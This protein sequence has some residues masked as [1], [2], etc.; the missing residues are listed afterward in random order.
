MTPPKRTDA[1]ELRHCVYSL[2]GSLD[3]IC[4]NMPECPEGIVL[5]AVIE[6]GMP[7]VTRLADAIVGDT[8][9]PAKA[10]ERGYQVAMLGIREERDGERL[11]REAWHEDPAEFIAGLPDDQSSPLVQ[12]VRANQRALAAAGR[13]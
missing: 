11:P 13:G 4:T 8:E 12:M 6:G 9:P 7:A 3:A 10:W 5:R 2:I 1:E